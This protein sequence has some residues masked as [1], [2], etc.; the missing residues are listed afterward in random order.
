M[1]SRLVG[2]LALPVVLIAVLTPAATRAQSHTPAHTPAASSSN[3]LSLIAR[4]VGEW[5]G[6]AWMIM[7]PQGKVP[8]KQR[9]VV[10]AVAGG[11]AFTVKGLGTLTEAN[12][13][14]RVIHDAFAI[15]YV[16]HDHVT[17]RM[18]A[19][20][21]AEGGNWIDPE[22]T[23][24]ANSYSWRMTDPRAGLIRYEMSF[25]AEGRWVE[26]G[27]RSRDDGK[28]WMPFFE[29]TLKRKK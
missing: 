17:P 27:V 1:V 13:S 15:I 6:D 26:R 22:F 7:G 18:R 2:R 12:G 9:E 16:D 3:P 11:T 5:E 24:T 23:L 14:T 29:M 4:L 21:A 25:D 19:Y 8:A 10:E 28:T 20:V